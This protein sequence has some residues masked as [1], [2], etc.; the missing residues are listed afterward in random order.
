DV[1]GTYSLDPS[2][3]AENVAVEMFEQGNIIIN[4]IDATNLERS[5]YLTLDILKK[6]KAVIIALN[7]WD[8]A[9]HKGIKI[10]V[11]KLE[12]LL[13]I[14]V[15]PTC[16][17]TG[18]GIKKLTDRLQEAV[19]PDFEFDD[20]WDKIGSIIDEVQVITHR[21]HTILERIADAS[22]IPITGIPIAITVL[23]LCF[24][25]IRFVG[26][27]LIAYVFEPLFETLWL[28]LMMR[29]SNLMG[30]S[31]ILHDIV[32]GKLI[33]GNIEF[34]ESMGVLTTGIFVPI[35]AVLPYIIAFYF[36]LS[37]LEDFGYLPRLAILVDVLMHKVGLHGLGIIPMMLGLGCNVP[38][39]LSSRILE[40]KRERFIASTL[41]A[42]AIP[43]M[44]QIA[45]VIGLVGKYGI[46]GLS[47]VFI[48]LFIVWILI[49]IILNKLVK[50]RSPEIFTDIPPYRIP[51]IK[52]VIKK[53]WMRSKW[54]LKEAVPYVLLG[55][56][57]VNI[58]YTLGIFNI[59]GKVFAPIITG[60][61]GLP[62]EAVGALII[63]F[64]RKDLAIGMLVPLHLNLKQLIIS[65]VILTMH[66]PCVA[67][68]VVM[69][70]E[71]GFISML[72]SVGIMII[73]TVI[74]GGF[75]NLVL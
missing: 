39:A 66:F 71:L 11:E 1:P 54:F 36:I 16:A 74:V 50:G 29:L 22:V 48:T 20:K 65:S 14:P 24:W 52:T 70:K 26:E 6:N 47:C 32:I 5:L 7:M 27:S 31:G 59:I 46:K 49:G 8:E 51:H 67:T 18:E 3:S 61:F 42:I 38:G 15:I 25:L 9:K 19:N 57:V 64:L 30:S 60:I 2:S 34:M 21:H 37:L 45:M 56:F 17:L 55:V 35:G 69:V 53:V 33:D 41:L 10:N 75:L 13:G 63:G 73:A 44:A 58:L 23:L 40:T 72:K 28:P 4:V 43:C 62:K 68:F 12:E